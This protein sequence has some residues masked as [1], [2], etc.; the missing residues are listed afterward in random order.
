M[1]MRKIYVAEAADG[2]DDKAVVYRDS[3]WNEFRTKFY[4]AGKHYEPADSFETDKESAVHTADD[5]IQNRRYYNRRPASAAPHE[6]L[7]PAVEALRAFVV[8][9]GPGWPDDLAVCWCNDAYRRYG[10]TSDEA[11]L[12]QLLRNTAATGPGSDFIRSFKP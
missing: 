5:W 8:R 3:E 12:L 11:S 4:I 7:A 2:S 10:C 1:S 9:R 6:S